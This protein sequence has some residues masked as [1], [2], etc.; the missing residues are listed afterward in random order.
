[1]G[2]AVLSAS[3]TIL[4]QRFYRVARLA[5][6]GL[7]PVALG[8]T[9]TPAAAHTPSTQ[10]PGAGQLLKQVTPEPTVPGKPPPEVIPPRAPRPGMQPA[11]KRVSFTLRSVQ[12]KGNTVYTQ[13][14]LAPLVSKYVGRTVTLAELQ[15]M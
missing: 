5:L 7:L 11:D 9:L 4:C 6:A 1:M 14:Q 10:A 15:S 13:Q 12:F 3:R 8:T 2:I